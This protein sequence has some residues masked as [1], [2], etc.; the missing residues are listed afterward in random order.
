MAF[1]LFPKSPGKVKPD[2]VSLM[3]QTSEAIVTLISCYPYLVDNQRIVVVAKLVT[4]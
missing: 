3:D 1:K 2:K 4:S